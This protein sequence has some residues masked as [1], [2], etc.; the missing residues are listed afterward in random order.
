MTLSTLFDRGTEWTEGGFRFTAVKAE[1]S[2]VHAI[3]VIVEELD[4]AKIFYVTGDTLYNKEIF[5]DLPENIDIV[6]LPI[7]GAGN[8]MNET[9][10]VR[11][12][13]ACG[14]RG[15][16]PYH[17]GMFDSKIPD[18]FDDENKIILEVYKESE[19]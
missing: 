13:R 6:F 7:N 8:N 16:V 1:H 11:F 17:V 18:I 19:L 15:A 5:A 14:A 2:D 9:D 12:F 10:A 4:T 3:G